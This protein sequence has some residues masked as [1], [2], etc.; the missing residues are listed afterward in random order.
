MLKKVLLASGILA[1]GVGMT[2]CIA[3]TGFHWKDAQPKAGKSTKGIVEAKGIEGSGVFERGFE[4]DAYY[5]VSV[6]G[7][8]AGV[9]FKS[10]KFDKNETLGKTKKMVEDPGIGA[11]STSCTPGGLGVVYRTKKEVPFNPVDKLIETRFKAKMDDE[12]GAF[13]GVVSTGH[14]FDDGDGVAESPEDSDDEYECAGFATTFLST[15]GFE[16]TME[17]RELAD[18]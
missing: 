13:G 4:E 5:Y 9:T 12:G 8:V 2:G 3:Q 18:R 17:M 14:W 15:K 16:P 1:A 11:N 7:E 6:A 10:F